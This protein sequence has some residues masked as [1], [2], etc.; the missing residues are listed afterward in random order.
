MKGSVNIPII[1]AVKKWDSE[2]SD[3]VITTESLEEDFIER[4]TKK[5][6]QKDT[7]FLVACATGKQYSIDALIALDEAGYEN[8]VGLKGG[9][10]LWTRT[11]DN[12]LR[13][14]GNPKYE[15][16]YNADGDGMGIHSTGAG[17]ARMDTVLVVDADDY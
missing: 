13:R 3:N 11:F 17:F 7:R 15:T 6:P 12:S 14:R 9:F 10:N 4:V 8:L 2:K 16:L 5:F 1:K